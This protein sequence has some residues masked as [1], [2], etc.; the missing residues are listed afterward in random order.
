M[1]PKGADL[2]SNELQAFVWSARKIPVARG[3]RGV[4]RTPEG[5]RILGAWR[6]PE[7]RLTLEAPWTREGPQIIAVPAAEH[8]QTRF[9]R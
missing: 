8:S 9:R 2:A 5:R 3:I 1:P 4:L 7:G 6:I